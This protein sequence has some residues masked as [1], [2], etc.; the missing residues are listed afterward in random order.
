M[1]PIFVMQPK[2]AVVVAKEDWY[3]APAVAPQE[4]DR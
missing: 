2:G 1:S 3:T 4:G